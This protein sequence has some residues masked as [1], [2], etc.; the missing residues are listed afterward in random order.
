[1]S[2]AQRGREA[3]H[4]AQMEKREVPKRDFPD[5]N[6]EANRGLASS[7]SPNQPNIAA[8]S[9]ARYTFQPLRAVPRHKA[10]RCAGS[11]KGNRSSE[12]RGDNHPR[13]TVGR[14]R[15]SDDRK[16]R[17]DDDD[18]ATG[19][20]YQSSHTADSLHHRSCSQELSEDSS[21]RA[22]ATQD[23]TPPSRRLLPFTCV[24]QSS[25]AV[26]VKQARTTTTPR[27]RTSADCSTCVRVPR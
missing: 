5:V 18:N 17:Q 22:L 9:Q 26:E 1:M 11:L 27:T 8:R 14:G 10:M 20:Q 15:R 24:R 4:G 3:T 23:P 13:G 16:D 12:H 25:E 2:R 21:A 19:Q 7:V 6:H